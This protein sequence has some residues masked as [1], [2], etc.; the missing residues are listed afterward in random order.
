MVVVIQHAVH[1]NR[2]KMFEV[3]IGSRTLPI[4]Y[5]RLDVSPS[6]GDPV[7]RT[8]VRRDE[9]RYL[10]KSGRQGQ[11]DVDAPLFD[12]NDSPRELRARLL[13]KLSLEAQKRMKSTPLSV[14]EISRRLSTSPAQLYRLLD[15]KNPGKSMDQ[16]VSL[17]QVLDCEVDLIVR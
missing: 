4:P 8:F 14:R 7:V 1:S 6:P 9:V 11:F 3:T 16:V 17:L 13:R 15:E 2:K 5:T 12:Y 10:L